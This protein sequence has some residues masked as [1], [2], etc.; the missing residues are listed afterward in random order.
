MRGSFVKLAFCG[1]VLVIRPN[2]ELVVVLG[3]PKFV[4]FSTLKYSARNCKISPF[5]KWKMRATLTSQS[6]YCGPTKAPFCDVS[7]GSNRIVGEAGGIQIRLA[8]VPAAQADAAIPG[9][10]DHG[11]VALLSRIRSC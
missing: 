5:V 2:V 8:M 4:W 3:S 9:T 11:T 7:E 10:Y 1:D 6:A